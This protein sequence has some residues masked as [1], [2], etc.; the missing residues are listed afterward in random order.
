MQE[1]HEADGAYYIKLGYERVSVHD[2]RRVR[3]RG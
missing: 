2:C 3:A 1:E